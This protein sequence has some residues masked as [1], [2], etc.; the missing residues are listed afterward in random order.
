MKLTNVHINSSNNAGVVVFN[1]MGIVSITNCLFTSLSEEGIGGGLMIEVDEVSSQSSCNI[2]NSTF[3]HSFGDFDRGGGGI[4]V[5]F[6]GNATNNTVQL[7]GVHIEDNNW[8]SILL[9]F[10]DS[11][12]L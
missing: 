6:S 9:E 2:A 7:D 4:S 1:P 5:M 11:T 3:T 10:S 12:T 8:S